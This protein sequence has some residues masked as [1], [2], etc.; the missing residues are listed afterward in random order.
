MRSL[1]LVITAFAI[2][3]AAGFMLSAP[4]SAQKS[5]DIGAF[6]QQIGPLFQKGLYPEAIELAERYVDLAKAKYGDADPHYANALSWLAVRRT[7]SV[8]REAGT[9]AR[10]LGK[11]ISLR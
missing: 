10:F 3:L 8:S 5:D 1:Q 6:D 7:A 9:E 4:A 2:I 11:K